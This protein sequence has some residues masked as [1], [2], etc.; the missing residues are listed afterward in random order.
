[1]VSRTWSLGSYTVDRR[2]L[3]VPAFRRLWLASVVSAVGGSFSL[4][5]IPTQLFS[6]TGSSASIGAA[7]AVSFAALVLACLV[8]GALAD[9]RD[10]RRLLLIAHGVLALTYAALW[11]Q[12]AAQLRSPAVLLV[13]VACQ[14]L[15]FGAIMTTMGAAVPRVL[16]ADLLTAASSLSSLVRYTGAIVGPLLAGLLIP[17]VGLG[18]L[19]LFDAGALVAV[20]WAV[21]RLPA[22]PALSTRPAMRLVSAGPVSAAGTGPRAIIGQVRAGFGY[23]LSSRLLLGV[24][25]IDLTAT[26]FGMPMALAP[27][28]ATSTYAS[29]GLGEARTLALLY[30]AY[31]AG[32]FTVGLT[33]ANLTR[34]RCPGALLAS[35]AIAWGASVIAL[36]LAPGL[37]FALGALLAGGGV[38]FVLS[39]FRNA[40]TQAH[41]DDAGRGRI[42][43]ALTIVLIGGPQLG[44][45]LHGV[46]GSVLGPRP[47]I[48]LGG[49]LTIATVALAVHAVPDLYRT[50][51]PAHDRPSC[52]QKFRESDTS[53]G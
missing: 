2:P 39:T 16:P 15:S 4:I 20:L 14:G 10:R 28:L 8:G 18:S 48:C 7:A 42:Q 11:G 36:G 37:W 24:L 19:Y 3:A 30:A 34:A 44:A 47:T 40:I 43:G 51:L 6:L 46:A 26:V 29:A 13:L 52:P 17:V 45:V 53:E 50:T 1:V 41:S 5:A 38:N 33:S 23:L 21:Y 25:G 32:V 12:A 49:A 31:P 9:L 27:E 35:A 22:M